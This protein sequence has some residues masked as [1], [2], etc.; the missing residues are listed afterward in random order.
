VLIVEILDHLSDSG[1]QLIETGGEP[2][3]AA[4]LWK[5]FAA[6]RFQRHGND[7]DSK[8]LPSFPRFVYQHAHFSA[9]KKSI[10]V[11]VRPRKGFGRS[12]LARHL[13]GTGYDQ[14]AE[15]RLEFIPL[16]EFLV[17]LTVGPHPG[18]QHFANISA[19]R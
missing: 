13:P 8:P 4:G 5:R 11:T 17:F 12:L 6:T 1:P 18:S 16:W 9:G 7:H 19:Y 14:L 10:E 3:S 2:S 15:R